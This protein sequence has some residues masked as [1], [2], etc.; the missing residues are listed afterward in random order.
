M[1]VYYITLDLNSKET[2]MWNADRNY[3]LYRKDLSSFFSSVY[4]VPKGWRHSAVV[5]MNEYADAHPGESPFQLKAKG[6]ETIAEMFAPRLF[7]ESSFFWADMSQFGGENWESSAGSWLLYRNLHLY[8]DA[9]PERCRRYS[10]CDRHGIHLSGVLHDH[11]HHAA[12]HKRILENGLSGFYREAEAELRECRNPHEQDFLKSAMTGLL[13]V[14]RAAERFAELADRML[15]T[16]S[17]P[18]YRDNLKRISAAAWKV[19]WEKPETFY[20]ALACVMFCRTILPLFEGVSMGAN[21]GMLDRMLG[22]FYERDLAAG[23][24]TPEQAE[25]L[26]T[27]AMLPPHVCAETETFGDSGVRPWEKTSDRGDKGSSLFL[28]GYDEQHRTVCNDL[29]M[30][31]LDIHHTLRLQFPKLAVRITRDSPERYLRAIARDY[32]SGRNVMAIY[33][34]ETVVAAQKKA[35]KKFKDVCNY[36]NSTCWEIVVEGC[37][38]SA[39]ANCYFNLSRTLDLCINSD[40]ETLRD[41]GCKPEM[42]DGADSF[43][44]VLR[45]YLSFTIREIREMCGVI[46]TNGKLFPEV[47]PA[48]LFSAC[49]KDCI[50]NRKDYSEGGARY[51]PHGMP[52]FAL[53]NAVDSLLAIKSLCFDRKICT[54][55]E[56]LAAVRSDWT[57]SGAEDLRRE[58]LRSPY[59][60]DGS[61]ESG[62]LA[63][64][65]LDEIIASVKDLRDERGGRFQPGLYSSWEFFRWGKLTGPTPDG[66]HRGEVLANGMSPSRMHDGMNLTDILKLSAALDLTDFPAN[67]SLDITLPAARLSE[68]VL[69]AVLRTFSALGGLQL[70][71]NCV[72]REVLNDAVRNPDR[73]RDLFVRIY[74]LSVRFITL[75]PEWQNEI[76]TRPEFATNSFPG[77][78]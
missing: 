27:Q 30:M 73:H 20:E 49:L 24:I 10:A 63:K 69:T 21:Y 4:V 42:F 7:P 54:L 67:A 19:P 1:E 9:D 45:R 22:P 33:N 23:R 44:E 70:Q 3:E 41:T 31:I 51:N 38:H 13:S 57:G 76:M 36:V 15:E 6:Y 17:V 25:D 2:I 71:M 60:G 8:W 43:E 74:G 58:A 56:L 50:R 35:G 5:K 78:R 47:A 11:Y 37:E 55:P 68:E 61:P 59:Y 29:T 64:R 18:E 40:P 32:L 66:R 46:G 77:G 72:N 65:I 16:E 52:M 14:R 26:L 53:A 34:D 12:P 39:G 75:S 28:G 48:P 62:A